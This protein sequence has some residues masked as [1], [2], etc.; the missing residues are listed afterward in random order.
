[1]SDKIEKSLLG[2][3]GEYFVAAELARRNIYAQLT[4]GNQKRTDL[5]IFS[6]TT[7]KVLT[8]EVKSKQSTKWPNCKGINSEQSIIVFVD[9][10]NIQL[11]QRPNF[12]ILDNA[13][14]TSIIVKKDQ[15]YKTKHPERRTVIK[16]NILYLLD[17]LKKD[18]K[19]YAGCTINIDD[20]DFGKEKWEKANHKLC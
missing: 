8:V 6:S 20:I 9:F 7:N 3:A 10:Q 12:Y 14:W 15:E 13:D 19:P 11:N 4:L 1:M 18:G 2:I 5:L 17:E 16:N